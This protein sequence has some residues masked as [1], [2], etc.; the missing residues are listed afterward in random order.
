MTGREPDLLGRG[1]AAVLRVGTIIAVLAVGVGYLLLLAAGDD[2]GPVP[3][4]RLVDGGGAPALLG[5]GLL[6]LTLIPVA[7][8]GVAAVG[9]QRRGERRLVITSLAVGVFLVAS[10]AV[11][12]LLTPAG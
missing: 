11:A 9:F 10:L 8:L 12:L 1:I 2:P 7:A 3:L 5:L 6:G 4:V